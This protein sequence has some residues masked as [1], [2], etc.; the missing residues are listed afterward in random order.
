METQTTSTMS[1]ADIA[2]VFALYIGQRVLAWRNPS[3]PNA[4]DKIFTIAKVGKT[5]CS[6]YFNED[7]DYVSR[8]A[9]VPVEKFVLRLKDMENLLEKEAAEI[10]R[11]IFP[12]QTVREQKAT[13]SGYAVTMSTVMLEINT[14][15]GNLLSAN[16]Q[17]C[18][19]R[20]HLAFAYLASQGYA[21]PIFL[22]PGHPENG[23]TP[24]GLGLAVRK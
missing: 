19:S 23:K 17:I 2:K 13:P 8:Q 24:F 15:G 18:S 11:I 20:I 1:A 9:D 4:M 22:A 14:R 3:D 16:A 12:Q 10:A 7:D 5:T 21:I 6:G